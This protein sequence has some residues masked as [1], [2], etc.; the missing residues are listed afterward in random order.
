MKNANNMKI[1]K[2]Y[3]KK[4]GTVKIQKMKYQ[5]VIYQENQEIKIGF[6]KIRYQ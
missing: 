5:K 6:K 2:N 3:I 1:Q 4:Q